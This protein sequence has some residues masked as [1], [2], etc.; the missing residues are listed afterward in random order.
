MLK[1]KR[2]I[3][4][5]EFYKIVFAVAIPVMIQNGITNFVGFLDNVMVGQVGTDQMSG[6][7]IANQLL[8]IFNLCIF[9]GLSGAGIFTAQ[10][11]GSGDDKGVRDTFRFKLITAAVICAA[12]FAI[13][14][15]FGE[16]LIYLYLRGKEDVG[17]I[18]ATAAYGLDYLKIMSL[19]LIPFAL[20]QI[21]AS[22]L[23]ETGSTV[24]PMK[25]S[26]VSV[27]TNFVL[28]YMLIFGRFGFPAYG[29]A[30]AAA[31]TVISRFVELAVIAVSTHRHAEI[32]RFIRGVY[33]SL[34]IPG[35]LVK[36]IIL[37]GMPLLIN[38]LLWSVGMAFL[39]QCYSS[40]GLSVVA[41]LN[42]STT[43]SNFFN[44][45]FQALGSAV[46]IL[47]GQQLGAGEY[48]KAKDT[49]AK[50]I[51]FSVACCFA[52]GV[53]LAAAAPF[54]PLIYKTTDTVRSLATRFI[55][56]SAVCMPI[57]AFAHCCYFTLRSGGKTLITFLFDCVHIWAIAIPFV[58]ALVH[59]TALNIVSVYLLGQL[60]DLVKCVFGFIMLKRG[61]WLQ[62]IVAP[63]S[64]AAES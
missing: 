24:L 50:L 52:V 26:V 35:G 18:A 12:G 34:K 53:L 63:Q 13:L 48:G 42:I 64:A 7:A 3:G 1:V 62:K 19:G 5:R 8:F 33:R 30:G 45:V 37:R 27:L 31:A 38:E 59:F 17:D 58:Y 25:A 4:T 56:V 47:V 21:Y 51:F 57:F 54:I 2:L 28:N 15:L 16:K 44:I 49:A 20:T 60:I 40:R 39:V 14:F 41:A 9:G 29:V 43:V 36:N 22:T 32:H 23:R 11:H 55:L 6:V 61:I 10:F 46:A